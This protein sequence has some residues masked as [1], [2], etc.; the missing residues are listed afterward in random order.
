MYS[1]SFWD[2]VK[3]NELADSI[4]TIAEKLKKAKRQE[5]FRYDNS[6]E[7]YRSLNRLLADGYR[8]VTVCRMGN[9]QLLLIL[10]YD[11]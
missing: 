6:E 4:C 5:A 1:D 2:T 3:G 10:E 9:G 7:L 11:E 8:F